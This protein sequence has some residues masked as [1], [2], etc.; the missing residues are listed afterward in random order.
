MIDAQ[1][2]ICLFVA[3]Y[4]AL[5]IW[6]NY[7]HSVYLNAVSWLTACNK[8]QSIIVLQIEYVVLVLRKPPSVDHEHCLVIGVP[9]VDDAELPEVWVLHVLKVCGV[10]ACDVDL[11]D[12][13]DVVLD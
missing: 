8:Q 7:P 10:A 12:I 4:I 9:R 1:T 5:S 3:G 11:H 6:L 2:C 13:A